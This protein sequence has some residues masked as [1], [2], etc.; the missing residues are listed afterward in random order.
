MM[1]TAPTLTPI[2]LA[3]CDPAPKSATEP[4]T[5]AA[6]PSVMTYADFQ[7]LSQPP[8]PATLAYGDD[9]LQ[10]VELWKPDG[11]GPFPV[12]LLLHGGCWQSG[13]ARADIMHRQAAAL[14][15]KGV[16]V[17]SVEYR[18]VDM[19]GGGYPGT[20]ADVAAAAD[21]LARTGAEH[22]LDTSRV[23][24]MGHSAG[25]HLALWLA[26]RPRIAPTSALHGSA[27]LKITGVV[28]LGGLPDLAAART[29]AAEACGVDTV[30]RL[31]GPVTPAHP[32]PYADTSPVALLPIGVPQVQISGEDDGIAPPRFAEA[33]AAKALAKG[34]R[35]VSRT[36]PAQ[37]HFELIVPGTPAGDAAIDAAVDLLGR[38]P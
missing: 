24:A 23:V 36:I 4:S 12:V 2:A 32:D 30:D 34:E 20:F 25:G 19:P 35:V 21:L 15:A 6:A 27:P 10:V 3:A 28:S 14:V 8:A 38:K 11:K 9:P 37:G 5:K 33:Y 31:V 18:G 7:Q 13:V 16:A 22:D 1:L 17:W 29:E 26:A